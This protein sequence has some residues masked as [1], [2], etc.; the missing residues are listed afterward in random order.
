[1][2][3]IIATLLCASGILAVLVAG[4]D[5]IGREQARAAATSVVPAHAAVPM[6]P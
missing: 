1:M 2:K 6:T 3:E 4:F 5:G